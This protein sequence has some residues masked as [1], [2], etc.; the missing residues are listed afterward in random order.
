MH[1]GLP[2]ILMSVRGWW[3]LR[4]ARNATIP[5]DVGHYLTN[6]R[7]RGQSALEDIERERQL[8]IGQGAA[9]GKTISTEAL[10]TRVLKRKATYCGTDR[11]Q[12]IAELDQVIDEF[13]EKH[14][15][16]IPVDEAYAILKELETRFGR[17][18]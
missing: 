13:R 2:E 16:K 17:V 6:R 3:Y 5:R 8:I 9:D 18:E 11:E 14:G 4:I 10:L 1:M 7:E 12:Y 15:H